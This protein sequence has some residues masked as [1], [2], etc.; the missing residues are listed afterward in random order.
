MI[1]VKKTYGGSEN[2][3]RSLSSLRNGCVLTGLYTKTRVT[4]RAARV[5]NVSRDG[6]SKQTRYMGALRRTDGC[7]QGIFGA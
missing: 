2:R 6:M 5:N 4:A 3:Y 1:D 7:V